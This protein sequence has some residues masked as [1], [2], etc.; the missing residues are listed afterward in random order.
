MIE[1]IY[2][3]SRLIFVVGIALA[4]FL[5]MYFVQIKTKLVVKSPIQHSGKNV[6]SFSPVICTA[7][8]KAVNPR[9][10]LFIGCGI[11]E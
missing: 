4:A 2:K 3:K 1:L 6:F 9:P 5:S 7:E 10:A 11:F 8:E